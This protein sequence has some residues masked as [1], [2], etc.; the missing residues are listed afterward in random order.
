MGK[1][2]EISD[3]VTT[4]LRKADLSVDVAAVFKK[5][6]CWTWADDWA[7]FDEEC[8]METPRDDSEAVAHRHLFP[9]NFFT[10]DGQRQKSWLPLAL[11]MSVASAAIGV[12]LSEI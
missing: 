11:T 12:T 6:G 7:W 5:H 3:I 2:A 1:P 10:I 4:R 9:L 8:F